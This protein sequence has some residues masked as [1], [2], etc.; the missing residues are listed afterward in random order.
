MLPT[1]AERLREQRAKSR[2]RRPSRQPW[3]LPTEPPTALLFQSLAQ[4]VA[5][6]VAVGA[7]EAVPLAPA[8][9]EPDIVLPTPTRTVL[10]E[11]LLLLFWAALVL[12]DGALAL[13][14]LID[15]VAPR[16]R[17]RPGL[18]RQRITPAASS[19]AGVS[20]PAEDKDATALLQRCRSLA[21]SL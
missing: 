18:Y 11:A 3:P 21:A 16:E 10:A 9:R 2:S 7:P 8:L 12:I 6:P 20:D 5:G 19:S 4:H 1:L 15:R 13:A 14:S 17:S